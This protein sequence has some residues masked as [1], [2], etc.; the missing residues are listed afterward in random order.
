MVASDRSGGQSSPPGRTRIMEALKS[1]LAETEFSAITTAEI[2]RRAEVTEPLI[3]KYFRDKRDLLHHILAEYLRYYI[4][5]MQYD[6]KG[7]KGALNKLRK[8]IW[9]HVHMYAT[10]RVFARI[11]IV[12]V[13]NHKDYFNS[14]AYAMVTEYTGVLLDIIEEGRA[15]GEIRSDVPAKVIRQFV[16]GAI[17]HACLPGVIFNRELLPDQITEYLCEMIFDGITE[18][19]ADRSGDGRRE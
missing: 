17:E 2:A 16:L 18:R 1:L 14:D 9:T 8:L 5:R 10:D 15:H 4:E 19:S 7:I 12:E 6:L 3:Y 13:R 11:L